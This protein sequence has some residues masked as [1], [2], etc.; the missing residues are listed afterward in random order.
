M[1]SIQIPAGPVY[2]ALATVVLVALYPANSGLPL[3]VVTVCASAASAKF[4]MPVAVELLNATTLL[5]ADANN[6]RVRAISLLTGAVSTYA[7]TSTLGGTDGSLATATLRAP[8]G[9]AVDKK[10]NVNVSSES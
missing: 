6:H 9:L 7:G 4:D 3:R 5:V 10:G 2:W 1:V 8:S